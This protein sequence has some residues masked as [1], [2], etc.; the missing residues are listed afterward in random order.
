MKTKKK[1]L[2]ELQEKL[3]I[4]TANSPSNSNMKNVKRQA[5]RAKLT[6]KKQNEKL[7]EQQ[8]TI[9]TLKLENEGKW[10]N[11]KLRGRS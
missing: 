8:E 10:Q 4:K 6:I 1:A 11:W 2:D 7:K 5:K 3:A 9:K